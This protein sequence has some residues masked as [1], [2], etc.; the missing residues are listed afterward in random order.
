MEYLGEGNA[1]VVPICEESMTL[2][3]IVIDQMQYYTSRQG[4]QGML[5]AGVVQCVGACVWEDIEHIALLTVGQSEGFD[6]VLGGLVGH[7]L[8]QTKPPTEPHHGFV[9]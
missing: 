7:V 9:N 2:V 6:T 4:Q 3:Q 1:R 5:C 8:L